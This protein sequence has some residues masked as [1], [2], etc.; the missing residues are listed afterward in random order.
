MEISSLLNV[1]FDGSSKY[2]FLFYTKVTANSL[3]FDFVPLTLKYSLRGSDKSHL[4]LGI[5]FVS[6]RSCPTRKSCKQALNVLVFW[7]V[8]I[9]L[10]P[11]L[12]LDTLNL[13]LKLRRVVLR[14][15]HHPLITQRA[16]C[17]HIFTNF[18]EPLH[19]LR[20]YRV[21][22]RSSL[23]HSEVE[24]KVNQTQQQSNDNAC[25]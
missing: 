17:G 3:I 9:E 22:K 19:S 7:V 6:E 13:P 14:T 21:D 2:L 11:D 24:V 23:G 5:L 12:V 16:E 1:E 25:L 18:R 10:Q 15:M 20:R 4:E 8:W